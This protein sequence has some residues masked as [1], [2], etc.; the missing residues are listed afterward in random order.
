MLYFEVRTK[1]LRRENPNA[2]LLHGRG[3]LLSGRGLRLLARLLLLRLQRRL[4]R[5]RHVTLPRA[6]RPALRRS[7]EA[8]LSL[9]SFRRTGAES[10]EKLPT[11]G[12][13]SFDSYRKC[14]HDG[15]RNLHTKQQ[16]QTHP[17]MDFWLHTQRI[18]AK[19][20]TRSNTST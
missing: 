9:E 16:P 17:Q 12:A 8:L 18:F 10:S 3:I 15:K 2:L 4:R 20:P 1:R 6:L 7:A 11:R 13:V 5:L 14:R 19:T